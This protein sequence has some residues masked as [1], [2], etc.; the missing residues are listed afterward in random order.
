MRAHTHTHTR[1]RAQTA[2]WVRCRR[3]EAVPLPAVPRGD[4]TWPKRTRRHLHSR[5]RALVGCPSLPTV[6]VCVCV[7]VREGE[8]RNPNQNQH[9]TT[10]PNTT[11]LI[12][13]FLG[14]NRVA[15][16]DLLGDFLVS[17]VVDVLQ[18]IPPKLL[19]IFRTFRDLRAWCACAGVCL[20]V[21]VCVRA[22]ACACVHARMCVHVVGV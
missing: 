19:R 11:H 1:A 21:C 6:C 8:R 16:E 14:H 22:C 15:L 3:I 13:H 10:Q 4:H 9:N 18:H 5:T 17:L 20:C 12:D 7:C 2:T